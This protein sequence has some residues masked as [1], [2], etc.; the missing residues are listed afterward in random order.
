MID[1]KTQHTCNKHFLSTRQRRPCAR[2]IKQL[3]PDH[4][5]DDGDRQMDHHCFCETIDVTHREWKPRRQEAL[6]M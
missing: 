4:F 2:E 5:M 6:N 3:D 1:I